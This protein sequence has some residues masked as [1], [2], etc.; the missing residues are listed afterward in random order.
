MIQDY[1]I[2]TTNTV[3]NEPGLK[4][5][6]IQNHYSGSVARGSRNYILKVKGKITGVIQFG[7]PTGRNC[8]TYGKNVLELKRM[9]ICETMPKN[10]ASWFI[11]KCLKDIKLNTDYTD[12][13][14]YAD[15]Q[16]GHSGTVYKAS[17][18]KYLGTQRQAQ[19]I[20]F[21]GKTYHIRI[22]YQKR[23]NKFTMTAKMIKDAL[24]KKKAKYVTLKPKHIFAY[25]LR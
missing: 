13:L 25:N 8:S 18:F 5:F 16:Y 12:I 20:K 19:G 21:K 7:I 11:A 15:P 10:T 14:S 6:I 2:N 1:T 24:K 3:L 23:L 17:N 22:C 9:V 4:D